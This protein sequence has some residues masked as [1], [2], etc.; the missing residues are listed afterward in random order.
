MPGLSKSRIISH[1]QCAK[2]LWL[3]VNAPNEAETDAASQARMDS[4]TKVGELARSLHPRGL[5]ID[6]STPATALAE[7]QKALCGPPRPLYE[8][9]FAHQ[10]VLVYVDLLLPE[11]GKWV[12]AEV[13]AS[14]AVKD[15]HYEDVAVQ[16]WVAGQSGVM[17]ARTEL[18]HINNQFVYPGDGRY[19]GL[20]AH[21]DISPEIGAMLPEVPGWVAA[22]YATL[23]GEEPAISPGSQCAKPFDCPFMDYCVEQAGTAAQDEVFPPEI[24]PRGGVLAA[25]L[26]EQGYDDLRQVPLDLL[27]KPLHQRVRDVS[28]SGIPYIGVELAPLLSA[29]PYP[30]YYLDFETINLAIPIWA[31]TRPYQMVPFQWSCHVEMAD[32]HLEHREFL[33]DGLSDPRPDFISKLLAA[34]G[35][36]GPLLVYNQ[37][38]EAGRLREL[39]QAYPQHAHAIDLMIDRIVDLLPLMRKHYYHPDMQGSWSIKKVLP[40]IAPD[41]DYAALAVGDGSMAMDAF[42]EILD[43]DTPDERRAELRNQLLEYCG[44]DTMAM[45]R[46]VRF[47]SKLFT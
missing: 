5:L 7:T 36:T 19:E 10:G 25:R 16:T 35:S 33:A 37:G 27:E 32:G 40:T 20:F 26:R 43:P 14:T 4:G 18:A 2:R 46:V 28:A 29:L 6:T 45:V 9:A 24:L 11:A 12:I 15:Y 13:K 17:V 21:E 31:G 38:F 23:D 44:L 39:A 41:L 3:Q 34:M 22:A 1:R 8:A 47:F 42:S 30:R